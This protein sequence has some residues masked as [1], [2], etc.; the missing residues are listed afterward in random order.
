MKLIDATWNHIDDMRAKLSAAKL[1]TVQQGA[2]H[3]AG[4][5]VDGFEEV[6]LARVFLVL[7]FSAL[8]PADQAFAADLVKGDRRLQPSTRVLSLLGTRGIER[9]WNDRKKST[10]HLAIPLLDRTFVANAP[11][12]AKLLADLDVD[13]SGLD[14]GRPIATRPLLGGRNGLFYVDEAQTARDSQGRPI[15]PAMGFVQRYG[16]HTVFGMGGAYVDGTLVATVLFTRASLDRLAADRF[17]NLISNFKMTTAA[18]L[19]A[20][21]IFE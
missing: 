8:P 4:M 20:K 18:L 7:P 2:Q 15:I 21:R 11:M 6:V 14:D 9:D 16:I 3:F 1:D 17:P 19:K 10:G 5:F 12:I 13:L